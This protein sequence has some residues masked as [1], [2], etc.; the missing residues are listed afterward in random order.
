MNPKRRENCRSYRLCLL[1]WEIF[2][3]YNTN[4]RLIDWAESRKSSWKASHFKTSQ[5]RRPPWPYGSANPF[6]TGYTLSNKDICPSSF[7][8]RCEREKKNMYRI[9]PF[10]GIWR[11]F[12]FSR[13]LYNYIF[14]NSRRYQIRKMGRLH[15]H[16]FEIELHSFSFFVS[17][18]VI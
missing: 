8:C 3:E 14:N 2:Q 5:A 16:W 7:I 1:L 17:H 18:S 12:F 9:F 10:M 15:F 6:C 4:E 11:G 13:S